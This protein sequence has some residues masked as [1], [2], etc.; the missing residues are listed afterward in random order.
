MVIFL[1]YII[2]VILTTV[3]AVILYPI[4]SLFWVIGKIGY[5][6]GIISKFIFFH[7]NSTIKKL[8]DDIRKTRIVKDT[9]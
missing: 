4:A 3:L 2:A 5:Y 9:Q 6:I 1:S 7:T 8:W